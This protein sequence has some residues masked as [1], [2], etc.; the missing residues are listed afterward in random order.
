MRELTILSGLTA[1]VEDAAPATRP[2]ILLIHGMFAGAWQFEGFQR[3]FATL[4]YSSH[5]INLRGHH[6]SHAV[7]DLGKVSVLDYVDDA[8]PV[9]RAL[10]RP[11]VIGH[12]MGGLIAQKLAEAGVISAA[13][14]LCSAAPKGIS[15]L[16]PRL[17]VKQLKHA[18]ELLFSRP[19]IPNARD[20]NDLAFNRIP[21]SDRAALFAR[22]VPESGRAG[23]EMSFGTIA[24]DERKVRCP[25]LSV[26]AED[27]C[28]VAP[29]VGRQIARKYGGDHLQLAKHGHFITGEPGWEAV[30]AEIA[31][32]LEPRMETTNG[33]S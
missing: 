19:I 24:V 33:R 3:Y 14:L 2:P 17:V 1:V 6:G 27:D 15:L 7:T 32:W 23:R 22:L 4:G 5:A 26:A 29:R 9:A 30:A 10:G 13:V 8:L 20:I 25:V 16:T 18:R 21:P 12:S 11:I 31:R 28:F